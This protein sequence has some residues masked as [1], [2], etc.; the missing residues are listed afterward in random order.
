MEIRVSVIQDTSLAEGDTS[1]KSSEITLKVNAI[2]DDASNESFLNEEV[3]GALG[4]RESYQTVK[5]HVLNNSVEI[6]QTMPLTI[7]TE[8]VNGQFKKEI[9]VKTCPRNVT[10]NYQVEN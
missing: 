4:L 1:S 8:S 10:G 6:F 2:L 9:E 5:V 7:E 3:A